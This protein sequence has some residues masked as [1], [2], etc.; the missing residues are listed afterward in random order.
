MLI[1]ISLMVGGMLLGYV[2]RGRRLRGLPTGITVLI[3]VLLFLLGV[4]VGGN[5]R[6]IDGL[7]TLGIE[8]LG[9][10]VACVAGSVMMAWL[11]WILI[12]KSRK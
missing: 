1:V 12:Y 9:I 4:E 2:F 11:L 7:Y 3:W 5:R 10:A 8:A 6:I